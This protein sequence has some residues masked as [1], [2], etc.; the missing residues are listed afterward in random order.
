MRGRATRSRAHGASLEGDSQHRE[1]ARDGHVPGALAIEVLVT[2]AQLRI[3]VARE[4]PV[5]R[6]R[7]TRADAL[8]LDL[9]VA[10]AG[11][12]HRRSREA[13]V[14]PEAPGLAERDDR[15]HSADGAACLDPR[16][17]RIGPGIRPGAGGTHVV[18]VAVE[19][20][21]AEVQVWGAPGHGEPTAQPT[22]QHL[23]LPGHG[24]HRVAITLR[25]ARG[26]L[27]DER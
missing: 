14:T 4:A 22:Q 6:A 15:A 1:H 26:R 23:L 12:G 9:L 18:E 7:P 24:L 11:A 10:L 19:P 27:V 2:G 5:E 21:V 8:V 25:H 13:D 16:V 17:Q 3:P 20:G